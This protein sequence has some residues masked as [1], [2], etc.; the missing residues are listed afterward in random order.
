MHLDAWRSG[1]GEVKALDLRP[2]FGSLN[3]LVEIYKQ[4]NAWTLHVSQR[5]RG[6]Y[7]H[8]LNLVLRHKGTNG[9]E[10]GT[11]DCTKFDARAVDK[12]Y[13]RLQKGTRV[14]RRLN[15]ANKC[16]KCMA[17]AWDAVQRLYPK[18]VPKDN[19]FRGVEMQHGSD[20]AKAAT[21]LEAYALHQA[22][23]KAGEP[24]LAVVPIICF[25]WHQRPENVLG[26]Y[27]TWPN[28]KPAG[29]RNT[30]LIEHHKTGKQIPMPLWDG[31][32]PLF[33]ELTQ[34]LDSLERLGVPIVL[35][36]PRRSKGG[37]K[38]ARPFLMRTARARV[39][40]AARAAGL[41][42]WLTME[43]CRHGGITE[44]GDA[45]GTDQEVRASTGHD[46]SAFLVYLK[47]TEHQRTNAQRKRRI[48]LDLEK[49][50][51]QDKSQNGGDS[52][53]SE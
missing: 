19:P 14:E 13:V 36:R 30:V 6:M 23:I 9:T 25:E 46:S 49:E 10:V 51:E 24:H 2:G 22:L 11:I 29:A 27:M 5:S 40:K 15:T 1:R 38:I 18:V 3:W 35:M 32:I 41:P 28:Y 26:G 17:R 8:A 52:R 53:E 16:M 50:Q 47:Q 43:A 45:G 33:P 4:S 37:A 12:L 7:V 39:R 42:D 21:R 34:Y 48:Y 31:P 44:L 20:T